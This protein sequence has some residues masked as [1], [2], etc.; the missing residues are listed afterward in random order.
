MNGEKNILI[1]LTFLWL[2]TFGSYG[3]TT[4][5]NDC[6]R[7]VPRFD[8]NVRLIVTT[9]LGG[10][11]PDDIQS[12]IHLLVCSDRIDIEG[13][14]SS[15]AWVDDPDKTEKLRQTVEHFIEVLPT[16]GIHSSGYPSA[17]YLRS[18]VAQGQ[19]K[20]H[21]DG[22]GEG[23]DSPGSDLIVDAIKKD[24]GRPLWVAA[25]GG[26]NT[27]AQ[28]LYKLKT[29]NDEETFRAY[30]SKLRI[31]DILGQ[32]DAGAYIAKNYPELVYIRNKE[33]YGWAPNDQWTKE[34]IQN[35][36]PLGAYYPNRIW[37]TEGDSPSF[38]Y[39]YSNGLN[40]PEHPEYGGWGGRFSKD[41][42]KNIRGMDFIERSGKEE[43]VFDDYYM[44]GSA[45]EGNQSIKIWEEAIHNDFAARMKWTQEKDFEKAN[46]H[47]V[48]AYNGDTGRYPVYLYANPGDTVFLSASGSCD[49]DNDELEY[50]WNV[51]EEPSEYGG[52]IIFDRSNE[53]DCRIIVPE[54]VGDDGIHIILEVSDN[55]S[56]KLTSY[57]RIII[58][59]SK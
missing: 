23:K 58:K 36:L 57:R 48:A 1:V 39:V 3:F 50:S 53:R 29:T 38:L 47:P 20:P 14:I 10:S 19:D 46:H 52:Q 41:R 49:P 45:P 34:N 12:M 4:I 8:G 25:W 55:G 43:K 24:D 30:I 16:L 2:S 26:M 59:N 11:D 37:A 27:V 5:Y 7:D 13:L 51:Y 42:V 28:A 44:I 15:E 9:D 35:R 18:I 56:P 40:D 54:R 22:V 6:K 17:E 31:Y 21:M 32:D 33:V